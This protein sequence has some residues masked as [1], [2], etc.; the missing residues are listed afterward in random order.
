M[1]IAAAHFP[2]TTQFY[3]DLLGTEPIRLISE[4]YAEFALP[5]MRLGIYRPR[6][7]SLP[8]ETALTSM[9][10]CLQV[11]DLDATIAHLDHLGVPHGE[12]LYASHGREIYAYDP[13]G[14]R[15]ICYQPKTSPKG[16]GSDS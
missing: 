3:R 11:T 7:I 16:S 8:P 2:Q 14:N 9:S 15:L 12:I 1:T 13:D 4:V 6:Q 10:L 5:G